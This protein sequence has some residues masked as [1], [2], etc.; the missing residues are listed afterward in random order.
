[1]KSP[2]GL[3]FEGTVTRELGNATFTVLVDEPA[4]AAGRTAMCRVGGRMNMHGINV[5]VGD[6]VRIEVSPYDLGRG[7]IVRRLTTTSPDT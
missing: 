4:E 2:K 5:V 7:R 3:I 1:M 6:R